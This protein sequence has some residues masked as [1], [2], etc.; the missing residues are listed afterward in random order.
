MS[1]SKLP[2]ELCPEIFKHLSKHDLLLMIQLSK[3]CALTAFP[4]LYSNLDFSACQPAVCAEK[5]F[6][7]LAIL[8]THPR[9]EIPRAVRILRIPEM[10][11]RRVKQ[12]EIM[13]FGLQLLGRSVVRMTNLRLYSCGLDMGLVPE[14][15]QAL[16]RLPSL[17]IIDAAFATWPASGINTPITDT[18]SS[19]THSLR[20]FAFL[21]TISLQLSSILVQEDNFKDYMKHLIHDRSAQLISITL[22][23]SGIPSRRFI[24]EILETNHFPS[25]SHLRVDY[26]A[27]FPRVI[28]RFPKLRSLSLPLKDASSPDSFPTDL[29][30]PHVEHISCDILYLQEVMKVAP[31][32]R[33]LHFEGALFSGAPPPRR[34][35]S[36][37]DRWSRMLEELSAIPMEETA[38]PIRELALPLTTINFSE[39]SSAKP[40]FV[41]IETLLLC[42][43]RDLEGLECLND[44][45]ND[46]FSGMPKLHTFLLSDD[47]R[48]MFT[49]RDSERRPFEIASDIGRQREALKAWEPF[50]PTLRR[51]SFTAQSEWNKSS[52]S[53]WIK[54]DF[55]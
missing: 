35:V 21:T 34:G 17:H 36:R 11:S 48:A 8:A 12:Q 41:N 53:E 45:G 28:S 22:L 32:V 4:I 54:S 20:D 27:I 24:S 5:V 29:Y 40:H 46:L 33:S 37:W 23:S 47:H 38:G 51:V 49:I 3:A 55:V 15:F 52:G 19:E 30:M 26:Q 1:F 2:V 9:D 6:K 18:M 16:S 25:V 10:D 42:A 13:G 50:C 44:L 39:L 7:C 43:L 14:V 31:K